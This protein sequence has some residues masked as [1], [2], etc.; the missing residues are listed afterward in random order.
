[1][2]SLPLWVIRCGH[3]D[4]SLDA[5]ISVNT[6]NLSTCGLIL[7][8]LMILGASKLLVS[9]LQGYHSACISRKDAVCDG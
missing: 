5:G 9:L 7:A 3:G 4:Q 8:S 1:M 2:Y 6:V